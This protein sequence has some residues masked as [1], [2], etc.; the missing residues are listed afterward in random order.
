MEDALHKLNAFLAPGT[1]YP[2]PNAAETTGK[3]KEDVFFRFDKALLQD[4]EADEILEL[5]TRELHVCAPL[6][7]GIRD[8]YES[9]LSSGEYAEKMAL[10]PMPGSETNGA[11]TKPET[12]ADAKHDSSK[13]CD[14]AASIEKD[15]PVAP[16][17]RLES[18][19]NGRSSPNVRSRRLIDRKLRSGAHHDLEVAVSDIRNV[20]EGTGFD[21]TRVKKCSQSLQGVVEVIPI[22]SQTFERVAERLSASRPLLASALLH[23]WKMHLEVLMA[24][25]SRCKQDMAPDAENAQLVKEIE[26]LTNRYDSNR[27]LLAHA[28]QEIDVLNRQRNELQRRL[29]GKEETLSALVEQERLLFTMEQDFEHLVTLA[30]QEL[31]FEQ[32]RAEPDVPPAAASETASDDSQ[33]KPEDH[34]ESD[35]KAQ[36]QKVDEH[37]EGSEAGNGDE[38]GADGLGDDNK[39]STLYISEMLGKGLLTN[40]KASPGCKQSLSS[41]RE[42]DDALT[43]SRSLSRC[44]ETTCSSSSSDSLGE[45]VELAEE[46]AIEEELAAMNKEIEDLELKHL[47]YPT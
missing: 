14:V 37:E 41:Q 20:H 5:L 38:S 2:E 39:E 18:W 4:L 47:V 40:A 21:W 28:T 13:P 46:E 3:A 22:Y 19:T 15:V 36:L 10:L 31:E 45:A 9:F 12:R 16:N 35:V 7:Q 6:L 30:K 23:V 32:A 26:R 34:R 17:P 42:E 8:Q 44:S 29:A 43:V 27:Q 1:D 24:V 11:S 25:L 33:E